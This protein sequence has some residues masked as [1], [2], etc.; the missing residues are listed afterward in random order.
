MS[1]HINPFLLFV[2]ESLIGMVPGIL[3]AVEENSHGDL[4]FTVK[5][6]CIVLMGSVL[7]NHM[8]FKFV[9]SDITCVDYPQQKNRFC[10]IYNFLSIKH[11]ARVFVKV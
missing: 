3:V 2:K 11:Q 1:K 10:L 8:N 4:S 5:P 7:K 6:E 9:L